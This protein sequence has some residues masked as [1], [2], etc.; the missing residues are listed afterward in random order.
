MGDRDF[1]ANAGWDA[2]RNPHLDQRVAE[3]VGIIAPVS[4]QD[5]RPRDRGQERPRADVV[6]GLACRQEHPDRAA[7]RIGQNVQ[8]R[9]Q[10][11][12]RAPDQTSAPPF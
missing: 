5:H 9:V 8:L 4:E 7:L 1:S 12:L 2:R 3:P 6:R 10:P 11:A